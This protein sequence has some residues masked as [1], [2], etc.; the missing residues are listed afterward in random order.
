MYVLTRDLI[1][2]S[3]EN[4]VNRGDFSFT[5]LMK[6][7]GLKATEILKNKYDFKGKRVAILCGNGNNGGDGFVI[8]SEPS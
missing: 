3:E 2:K 5:D 1:R 6:T 7:A 4:A 8:A